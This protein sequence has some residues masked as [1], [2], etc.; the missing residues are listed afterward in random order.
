MYIIETQTTPKGKWSKE[1]I[2]FERLDDAE[3]YAERLYKSGKT[4]RV[5]DKRYR[6]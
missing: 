1:P 6:K 2:E 3:K 4:A 5:V